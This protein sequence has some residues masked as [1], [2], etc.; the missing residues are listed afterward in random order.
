VLRQIL[1]AAVPLAAV[2]F[3]ALGVT[4]EQILLPITAQARG[5]NAG[6]VGTIATAHFAGI[7]SGSLVT[8]RLLRN[9][10]QRR[11]FIVACG[12][13]TTTLSSY[14]TSLSP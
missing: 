12:L 4:L 5:A 8:R 10:G 1:K 11:S 3:F 14:T 6:L 13:A 9:L 7:L 2:L